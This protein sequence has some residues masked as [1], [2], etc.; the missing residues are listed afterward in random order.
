LKLHKGNDVWA[1]V[2]L[3]HV[4][5]SKAMHEQY[6]ENGIHLAVQE[7]TRDFTDLFQAP[8]ELPPQRSFDHAIPLLPNTIPINC[9]PYRY[10]PQ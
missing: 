6:M 3:S 2:V 4:T 5:E 7:V 1:L 10:A 8:S 9:R